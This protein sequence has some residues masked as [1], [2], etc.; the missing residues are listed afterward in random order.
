MLLRF[1]A[2][3]YVNLLTA[4]ARTDATYYTYNVYYI[5]GTNQKI[6]RWFFFEQFYISLQFIITHLNSS[7]LL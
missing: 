6:A 2:V 3:N 5:Y 7:K 1:E 4:H